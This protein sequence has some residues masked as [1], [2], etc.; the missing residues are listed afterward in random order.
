MA[1]L[2]VGMLPARFFVQVSQAVVVALLDLGCGLKR[3]VALR[4]IPVLVAI[5]RSLVS[6]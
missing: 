1:R 3:R 2:D 4:T 5:T 6:I